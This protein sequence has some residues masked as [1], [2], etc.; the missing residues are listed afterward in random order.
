MMEVNALIAKVAKTIMNSETTDVS[1]NIYDWDWVCGVGIYGVAR[2]WVK[3]GEACYHDFVSAWTSK[4]ISH[5][6]DN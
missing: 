2:A 3:T 4:M 5:A 1:M 6:Y